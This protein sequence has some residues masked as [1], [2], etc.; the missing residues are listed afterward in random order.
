M[1]ALSTWRMLFVLCEC[2]GQVRF[3]SIVLGMVS[4]LCSIAEVQ[5][6]LLSGRHGPGV[7]FFSQNASLGTIFMYVLYF[8]KT[9]SVWLLQSWIYFYI[10]FCFTIINHQKSLLLFS[11]SVTSY[12]V[13]L[14]W[15]FMLDSYYAC[16]C[17]SLVTYLCYPHRTAHLTPFSSSLVQNVTNHL[18]C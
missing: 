18:F 10:D 8:H 14:I 6:C 17:P 15:V 5:S 2:T 12:R 7:F 3:V 9:T 11:S 4:G 13:L 1:C 16:L